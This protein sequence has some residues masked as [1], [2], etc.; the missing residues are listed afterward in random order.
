MTPAVA[1]ARSKR[2]PR[3]SM[4]ATAILLAAAAVL[5]ATEFAFRL[6]WQPPP[7]LARLALAGPFAGTSDGGVTLLPG[8]RGVLPACPGVPAT[9]FA[10]DALGMR[11][12]GIAGKQPGERRVLVVGDSLVFGRGVGDGETL[13]ART[14]SALRARS[15]DRTVGNGGVPTFGVSHAVARL[16]SLDAPFGADAFVVCTNLDDDVMDEVKPLRRVYAGQLLQ[17][18]VVRLVATSW[19]TRLAL[20]S[21]LALWVE[22]CLAPAWPSSLPG[23]LPLD[24]DEAARAAGMPKFAQAEHGLFLDVID[25][26]TSW[27]EGT[28]PVMPRVLAAQRAALQRAKEIVAQRPAWFVVLP[29]VWQVD[30][31]RRRAGLAAIGVPFEKYERGLAQRRLTQVARD[32]G[33]RALDATPMLAAEPDHDGLFLADG[34]HLSARGNDVLGKWL[35]M[36]LASALK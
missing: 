22:S 33:L 25:E 26:T 23:S 27:A 34:V 6:L 9:R 19:R 2:R 1:P 11:G 29:T 18:D 36:E 7:A 21:R 3:W 16:A 28:E 15:P 8:P 32:L 20:R 4:V 31:G 5:V 12:P 17:G 13:P 30:E 35:A 14:E 24:A 10:V